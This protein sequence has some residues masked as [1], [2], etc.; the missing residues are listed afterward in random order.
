MIF[1]R[2]RRC[3]MIHHRL[4]ISLLCC[5][6]PISASG[7]DFSEPFV[8]AA[9]KA[10]PS[11]VSIIIHQTSQKDGKT[12][13]LKSGFGSGTIISSD[14][15]VVTNHHV[16][17]KGAFYQVFLEDGTECAAGRLGGRNYLSDPKTD[18]ALL[19][20]EARE[21]SFTPIAFAD[22][23]SL[24]EGEWVLALGNPYGLRQS[25]TSG[26][27]S[28]KGR[29]D[30]GFADIEDFIQTDVPINPGNSGGPL[31][32]LRGELVGINTAI[33]SVSGG[34][35]GIS[36][37]IPSNIVRRVCDELIAHGRIRRGWLG[38]LAREARSYPRG[39]KGYVEVLSVVRDS[40]A[41]NSGIRKGDIIREID[42]RRIS[43]LGELIASVGSK[44]L[45]SRLTIALSREGRRMEIALTLREKEQPRAR[46][47]N[48]DDLFSL[49]GIEL[50]ENSQSGELFISYL[51][52]MGLGYQHGLK[53]GDVI[54][55]LNGVRVSTIGEFRRLFN[56]HGSTIKR[57]EILRDS[58]NYT[59]GFTDESD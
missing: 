21:G 57:L 16:L 1:K 30:I 44:P 41:D 38:F 11:V 55:S 47:A 29:N 51:S 52:P 12:V 14:G 54:A 26:I 42:G 39:E 59:I 18:I 53:R 10:S 33:R 32:N 31:V 13:Y 35:Q 6:L 36:F 7:S 9:R 48:G 58:R 3:H 27:V 19:K 28:S 56:R 20:I 4:F 45:G 46:A 17:K 2:A 50:D 8:R 22:S 37:A 24:V 34:Y 25:I 49:Y 40:P 43:T 23:D 15:Y 5:I